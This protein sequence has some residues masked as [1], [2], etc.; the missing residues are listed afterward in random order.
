M[1]NQITTEDILKSAR[2]KAINECPRDPR[3]CLR[4]AVE[5]I[6]RDIC[7]ST[8]QIFDITKD[9]Y[10]NDLYKQ[11]LGMVQNEIRRAYK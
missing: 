8:C 4:E 3:E 10:F 11:Y 9:E 5:E 1:I 6:G 7:T 2:Y